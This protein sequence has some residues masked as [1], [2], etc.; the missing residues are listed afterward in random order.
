V[1]SARRLIAWISQ[2]IAP[3][4]GGFLADGMFEPL[5]KDTSNPLAAL[6]GKFFGSSVGSGISLLFFVCGLVVVIIT[7]VALLNPSFREAE[8]I[9]ETEAKNKA[10][11]TTPNKT[12]TAELA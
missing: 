5:M 3:L 8:A 1:F 12:A 2:P 10:G 11:E 9:M 4:I 7:I 6:L